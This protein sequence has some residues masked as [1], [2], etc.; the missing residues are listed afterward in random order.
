MKLEIETKY[1]LGDEVY[2]LTSPNT[3]KQGVI[4]DINIVPIMN[5]NLAIRYTIKYKYDKFENY[6]S[7]EHYIFLDKKEAE[8]YIYNQELKNFYNSM[9]ALKEVC[10]STIPINTLPKELIPFHK[11]LEEIKEMLK[12][13]YDGFNPKDKYKF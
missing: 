5:D 12:E 7:D 11:K 9:E 10:I 8:I 2:F 6:V 13:F 3:Y 4:I 1:N